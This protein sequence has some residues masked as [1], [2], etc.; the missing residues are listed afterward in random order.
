MG[1]LSD[2]DYGARDDFRFDLPDFRARFG[3]AKLP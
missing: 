1:K 2:A 3:A